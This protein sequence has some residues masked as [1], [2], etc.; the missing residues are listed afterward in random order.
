MKSI[1]GN[2]DKHGDATHKCP[3]TGKTVGA[4]F[5]LDCHHLDRLALADDEPTIA[6]TV[7][8]AFEDAEQRDLQDWAD[9]CEEAAFTRAALAGVG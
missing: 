1:A 8:C 2:Y 5:C 3:M 9:Y 6:Y 7:G 4:H